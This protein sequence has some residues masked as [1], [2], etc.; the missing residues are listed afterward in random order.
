MTRNETR[1]ALEIKA[2]ALK[3]L[4]DDFTEQL[5]ETIT[6]LEAVNAQPEK[7]QPVR[8]SVFDS[9]MNI[10]GSMIA[11]EGPLTEEPEMWE[12]VLLKTEKGRAPILVAWRFSESQKAALKCGSVY[13]PTPGGAAGAMLGFNPN[14]P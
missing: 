11:L 3:A 8:I 13:P 9:Q 5:G 4:I 12:D 2:E 14:K 7:E 6:V 10:L 1:I